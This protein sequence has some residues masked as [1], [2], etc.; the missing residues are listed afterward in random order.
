MLQC[1]RHDDTL[2]V[3][4]EPKTAIM[5]RA[6]PDSIAFTR[7]HRSIRGIGVIGASGL[8]DSDTH[9]TGLSGLPPRYDQRRLYVDLFNP[10]GLE[11]DIDVTRNT[12]PILGRREHPHD[13][14]AATS[15]RKDGTVSIK[16]DGKFSVRFSIQL[17]S[18]WVNTVN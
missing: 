13:D 1:D 4:S 18:I 11:R 2:R 5:G 15:Q 16:I 14:I 7:H 3:E 9:A 8:Y 6:Q 17:L 12:F 10:I